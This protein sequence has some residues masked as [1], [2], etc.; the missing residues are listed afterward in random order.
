MSRPTTYSPYVAIDT[1]VASLAFR[2]RLPPTL[3][4][5]LA[6]RTLCVSFVTVAEL[7]VWTEVRHWG[8]R[9][10]ANLHDWLGTF[11]RLPYDDDVATTWGHIQAAAILRGRTRP[12]N[13]TWIAACCLQRGIPLAT[14]NI[15]D[16][17]D[18]A[19][20]DGL[21]LITE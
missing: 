1:D 11:V 12:A 18:F 2:D 21:T 7:T 10:R 3:A 16:Y 14:R 8:S 13:D 9:N 5:R 20:H 4:A 6:G 19:D 15:K 17:T